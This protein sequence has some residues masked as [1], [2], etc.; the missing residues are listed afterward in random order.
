MGFYS[1][2]VIAG[3]AKRHGVR[4]LPV[5]VNSSF[6]KVTIEAASLPPASGV[7]DLSS[8]IAKHRVCRTHHVRLGLEYVKHVGEEEAVAIVAERERGGP[9]RSFDDLARRVALKE[10]ALRS[11]A[12]VG[13]FDA[14]GEPRRALLW[15]ARDAH[16]TSPAFARPTLAFPT[17]AA[18]SL[19]ALTAAEVTALDYRITGVPTGPQVMAFYREE[20]DRRG[21]LRSIDLARTTHG[22]VVQVSGAIVV[23]QHPETAKGHVFLSLEDEVGIAN[24]IVRPATYKV[25]KAVIDTSPAVVV[26]GTLQHVDGVVSVLARRVEPVHLFVRLAAREWQ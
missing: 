11:L 12:L 16:R 6:A 9:Y 8:A 2:A 22:R 4:V 1:P 13:A 15:R 25:C 20:L 14:L 23:K 26:E 7:A 24:V 10:E 3:D 19:P 5:D 18:P 17:T 21:V